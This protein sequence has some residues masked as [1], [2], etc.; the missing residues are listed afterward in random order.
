MNRTYLGI[1]NF[2]GNCENFWGIRKKGEKGRTKSAP[3]K[4][5]RKG[6]MQIRR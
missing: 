5:R 1:F 2:I 4:G 6:T 3:K